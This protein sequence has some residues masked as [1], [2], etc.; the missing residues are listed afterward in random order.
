MD[1]AVALDMPTRHVTMTDVV[2]DVLAV[3]VD[4]VSEPRANS[5]V[6]YVTLGFV[7][8]A[9]LRWLLGALWTIAVNVFALVNINVAAVNIAGDPPQVQPQAQPQPQPAPLGGG[10]DGL[11]VATHPDTIYI[12]QSVVADCAK[13]VRKAKQLR[14]THP[15]GV[16]HVNPDCNSLYANNHVMLAKCGG[17]KCLHH[18]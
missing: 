11:H 16:F 2:E 17:P 12:C 13:E 14:A 1:V 7:L 10:Q 9:A 4:F 3:A 6:V 8:H 18:D 5:P 15:C